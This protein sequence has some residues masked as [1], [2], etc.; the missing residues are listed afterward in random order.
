MT[1]AGVYGAMAVQGKEWKEISQQKVLMVGAGSAG[2]GI[3]AMLNEA[4]QKHVSSLKYA[5]QCCITTLPH[6]TN[7]PAVCKV[8]TTT[9]TN[10]LLGLLTSSRLLLTQTKHQLNTVTSDMCPS[11]SVYDT[12]FRYDQQA[13]IA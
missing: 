3:A 5:V 8:C 9:V 1:L 11:G 6:A 2:T 10:E 13:K 4:M 12:L 7:E